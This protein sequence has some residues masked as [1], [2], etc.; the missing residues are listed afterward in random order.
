MCIII[1]KPSGVD[2]PTIQTLESCLLRNNHGFGFSVPNKKPFKTMSFSTFVDKLYQIDIETPCIIHF[3]YATHGS[4][5]QKN[6]HPFK[7]DDIAFAHN[8]V[9]NVENINDMTDSETAFKYILMPSIKTFGL[10]SKQFKNTI[11]S[12]ISTSKF[13]F[14]T[15]DGEIKTYGHFIDDGGLLYSNNSYKSTEIRQRNTY[16]YYSRF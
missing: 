6:C 15:D 7:V 5:N 12:I 11:Q 13:A 8:G 10:K 1:V 14:L 3:R 4:I 16:N 2:M 9:L